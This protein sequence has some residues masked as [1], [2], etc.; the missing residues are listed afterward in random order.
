MSLPCGSAP[1]CVYDALTTKR[2]YKAA[3]S[4]DRAMAIIVEASGT[5]FDPDVVEA[6]QRRENVFAALA[7]E[8]AELPE[9]VPQSRRRSDA[10]ASTATATARG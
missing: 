1:W 4:H 5:Q 8:L 3:F 9:K 2:V 7:S 6:L 10:A